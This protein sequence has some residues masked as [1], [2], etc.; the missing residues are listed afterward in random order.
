VTKVIA[1]AAVLSIFALA[2]V[3]TASA[4]EAVSII[5]CS[6]ESWIIQGDRGRDVAV[7]VENDCT[8]QI[9]VVLTGKKGVKEIGAVLP[10]TTRTV[11]AKLGKAE[12]LGI[13]VGFEGGAGDAPVTVQALK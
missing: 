13:N 10:G 11:I 2:P 9:L 6:N 1:F 5:D 12:T 8:N 4:G 3:H 7:T